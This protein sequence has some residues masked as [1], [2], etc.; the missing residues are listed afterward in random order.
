MQKIQLKTHFMMEDRLG[1]K[2]YIPLGPTYVYHCRRFGGPYPEFVLKNADG[3]TICDFS[4][5][6]EQLD[7]AEQALDRYNKGLWNI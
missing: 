2:I 3:R 4:T 6:N 5:S 1:N 7:I